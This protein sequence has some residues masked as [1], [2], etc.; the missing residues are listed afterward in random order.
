MSR[1]STLAWVL[2]A[3]CLANPA[4]AQQT[5]DAPPNPAEAQIARLLDW[6]V[7]LSGRPAPAGRPRVQALTAAD[8]ESAVCSGAMPQPAPCRQVVAAYDP[9]RRRIV[10]REGLDLA[11][12]RDQGALVH[13]LVHWL[14]H[15]AG[16]PLENASCA[17]V[18][19]LEREAYAVQNRFLEQHGIPLR[20]GAV[21]RFMS[22]PPG[23]SPVEPSR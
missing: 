23:E 18:F 15:A 3:G 17:A 19:R 1:R 10:H 21:L 4:P 6:A 14:Q 9:A 11:Q 22:C 13:E 16:E 20:M 2:V 7:R 5:P 8:M 12:V